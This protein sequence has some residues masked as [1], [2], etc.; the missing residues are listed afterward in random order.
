MGLPEVVAFTDG[1][2]E[3]NPGVGGWGF[4]CVHLSSGK[5]LAARGG[6]WRSTNN[7]MEYTAAIE[8]LRSLKR[9]TSIEIRT[10]SRLLVDTM[11][12]WADGWEKKGWRKSGGKPVKNLDLLKEL[13]RLERGHDVQWTWVRGHVG[14][15]GNEY[16][17]QLATRAIQ[18][19]QAGRDPSWRKRFTDSP[20]HV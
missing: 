3:P 7:R 11:T 5:A 9:R 20:V 2:C 6:E 1:G 19:I 16:V 14:T 8:L 12:Q 15:P 4:L 17:D 10:D 13:R 18:E